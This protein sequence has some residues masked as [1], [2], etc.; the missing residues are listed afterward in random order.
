MF[1]SA[2]SYDVHLIIHVSCS[3]HAPCEI[4][5]VGIAASFEALV[6]VVVA[7]VVMLLVVAVA[8]MVTVVAKALVWAGSVI[9]TLVIASPV[10]VLINVAA[11]LEID[12]EVAV[13]V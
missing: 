11:A 4:Q 8:V 1:K 12:L 7:E 10:R 13:S 9:D 3:H 2:F 6:L 5:S